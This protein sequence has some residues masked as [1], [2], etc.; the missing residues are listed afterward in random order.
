LAI[1]QNLNIL[2]NISTAPGSGF[3]SFKVLSSEMDLAEIRFI[4]KAFIKERHGGFLE[5]C[6]VPHPVR[7]L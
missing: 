5:K 3:T 2:I 4:R 1:L 6:P 7:D